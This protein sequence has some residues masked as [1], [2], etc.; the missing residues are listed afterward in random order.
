ML[1]KALGVVIVP[2]SAIVANRDVLGVLTPGS[3]GSTFGGNPIACAV[4]RAVIGLL[5]TGEPQRQAAALEE[6]LRQGLE[7]LL[8]EGVVEVRVHGLWAGL[9]LDPG[10]GTGR[11]LCEALARRGV[12]AKDTHGSSI[13]LS[14]PLTI[15]E[16]DLMWGL[17][18]LAEA[19]DEL[20]THPS[21]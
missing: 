7:K 3:H 11:D 21:G 20:A 4:G 1:G 8:G 16:K 9:D 18:R 19:V 12:L 6:P 5:E 15:G 13:R 17:D 14:P 10:L 2:L